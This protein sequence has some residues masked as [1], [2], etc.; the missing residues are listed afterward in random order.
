MSA[1]I[2]TFLDIVPIDLSN[3]GLKQDSLKGEV[4]VV[5]GSTSNVGLGYVRA[6]AWAGG[7]VVICGRNE[8]AGAEA[9]RVIDAENEPGTALYVK[10]DVT[11]ENDVKEL[12]K[13]ATDKFGKVDILI[14][15]AMNMMLNG[16]VLKSP[17][18]ALDQSYE[19]SGRGTLLTIQE[20]VPG[21]LE[22][23]HG[24]VAY[25]TTQFHYSP[26][27]IGGAIYCAGK[28]TATSITMSLANEI[29][30]YKDTG[31]GVFC[32]I[33]AGV[34]RGTLSVP[35]LPDGSRGNI[36]SDSAEKPPSTSGFD[37]PIPPEA[38]AAALVYCILH[39]EKL[40]CSGINVFDAFKAMDFPFPHPEAVRR[41][42]TRRLTDNEA[43]LFF[44][45][46]GPG[47]EG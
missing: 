44:A 23:K 32:M 24:V 22:R 39:A 2:D 46:I 29:G 47:F 25:S 30:A 10:C 20:F 43:T 33:P 26:P 27:M 36:A 41:R 17:V 13:K 8:E 21:M 7:K 35:V 3:T 16:P 9:A 15:N 40:H 19:I 28:S 45:A 14:N 34:G 6:I 37:G 12:A 42:E 4:A 1:S 5:T 11:K 31:V 18:S 38:N